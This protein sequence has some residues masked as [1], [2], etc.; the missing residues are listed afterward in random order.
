MQTY[1][2][3]Q[4]CKLSSIVYGTFNLSNVVTI[5]PYNFEL[6]HFKVGAF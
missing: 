3:T 4:A 5:D 6:Y 2:K 1:T